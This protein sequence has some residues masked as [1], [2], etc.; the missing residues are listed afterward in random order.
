MKL[1]LAGT[2]T[3]GFSG[4]RQM[5]ARLDDREKLARDSILYYLES[6]H[7]IKKQSYVDRIK[8]DGSRVFLDSGAFSSYTK[9]IE[10]DIRG[11]CDYIKRNA[12]VIEVV[13]GIMCASVLDAVG[14]P[15]KTWQNQQVMEQMGV[16][17]LPC[18][19]YGEDERYLEWYLQHY[20]YITIGGMVPIS[21]PQLRFW[22]D[23]IWEKYLVDGSGS[24]RVR[25]HGFGLTT[26]SLM[27]RYPWYS[28]DSSSWVQNAGV[29][30]IMLKDYGSIAMSVHS[31]RAKMAGQ[32]LNTLPAVHRQ[33]IVEM[34][35]ADGWSVDRL[36]T[37]YLARW[38]FNCNTFTV[39][40]RELVGKELRFV[41]EQRAL[42]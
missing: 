3:N 10:V 15:L 14:D 7:Y 27:K 26:M 32:H 39:M 13:D 11:Y 24:P 30:N 29:G 17:P 16:R 41:P 12:E 31:P 6:Y 36:T 25:V 23:R 34:L 42:F 22:L 1:Y 2:Y 21:T 33:R 5:Y 37:E 19:H 28:V 18:F 35:E 4:N 8:A 9:G 20:E 40:N 38:A